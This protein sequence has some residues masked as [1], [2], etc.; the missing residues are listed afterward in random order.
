MNFRKM[1]KVLFSRGEGYYFLGE[2]W[3]ETWRLIKKSQNLLGKSDL[4]MLIFG[5]VL[6]MLIF[7]KYI[8]YYVML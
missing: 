5:I 1:Y 4:A 8:L 2:K 3:G 6:A 7:I